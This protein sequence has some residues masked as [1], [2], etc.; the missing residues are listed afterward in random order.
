LDTEDQ[1]SACQCL[2][3]ELFRL[4]VRLGHVSEGA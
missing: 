3:A 1:I 4:H 2:T